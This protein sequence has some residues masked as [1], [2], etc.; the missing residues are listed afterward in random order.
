MEDF[1]KSILIKIKVA[2]SNNQINF[3]NLY[4]YLCVSLSV[5]IMMLLPFLSFFSN[6]NRS[7]ESSS[8]KPSKFG[9]F[10]YGFK[11]SCYIMLAFQGKSLV[12][13]F[14]KEFELSQQ[15]KKRTGDD[16]RMSEY[17]FY[18]IDYQ[19]STN[20]KFKAIAILW[21][22]I[23]VTVVGG[24]TWCIGTGTNLSES[25]WIAWTF[26]AD[27]G[28]HTDNIGIMERAVSFL[29][30]LGGMVIFAVVIGIVSEDISSSV[31]N[32][33]KGKSRVVEA[34]HTLILGQVIPCLAL[35]CTV[36][37]CMLFTP[38]KIS[39]HFAPEIHSRFN[40]GRQTHP[41]H[42]SNIRRK[43]QS[44]GGAHSGAHSASQTRA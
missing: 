9:L 21:A 26:V 12:S 25:V 30:T 15:T 22:A 36:L 39:I 27:P 13:F 17:I 41:H 5:I 7:C 23:G 33:R 40:A 10:E 3:Q 14:W 19:F 20:P 16:F 29:L 31:D 8:A 4:K 44:W 11:F 38:Y 35:Y 34:N 2:D 1:L 18:R 42:L 24:L 43:R 6:D 32:L 37:R 28:T